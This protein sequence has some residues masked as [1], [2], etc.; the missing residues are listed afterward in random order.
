MNK[1]KEFLKNNTVEVVIGAN[2]LSA[3]VCF[4]T[5]NYAVATVNASAATLIYYN[6]R[7]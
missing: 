4:L 7:V 2:A 1:V 6:C 3:V 5:G